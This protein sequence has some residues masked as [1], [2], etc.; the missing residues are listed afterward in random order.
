MKDNALFFVPVVNRDAHAHIS[1]TYDAVKEF[2]RTRKNRHHYGIEECGDDNESDIGVDLNRNYGFEFAHDD[3]GSDIH[4]CN[5]SYRGPFAFSEPETQAM[6][7]LVTRFDNIKVAV[8]LH[9]RDK[10]GPLFITPFNFDVEENH[11]L[12]DDFREAKKFYEKIFHEGAEPLG[13][14]TGNGA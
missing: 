14:T 9:A 7:N 6:K 1:D 13:Y 10:A 8:N 11:L 2:A 4:P 12:E 5:D 3:T